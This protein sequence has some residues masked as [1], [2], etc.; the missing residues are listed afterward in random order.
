MCLI[1]LSM[2]QQYTSSVAADSIKLLLCLLMNSCHINLFGLT[3]LGIGYVDLKH[4]QE[5]PDLAGWELVAWL[6]CFI[7]MV[8]QTKLHLQ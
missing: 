1:W 6:H 7:A 2:H 4:V 5:G 3:M 8:Q